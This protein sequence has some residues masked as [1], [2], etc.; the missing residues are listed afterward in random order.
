MEERIY[1][2]YASILPPNTKDHQ[3]GDSKQGRNLQAG[4]K[5]NPFRVTAYCLAPHG[6]YIIQGHLPRGGTIPHQSNQENGLCTCLQAGL[7]YH[8]LN[9]RPSFPD[10]SMFMSV[11]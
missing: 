7:V 5:Q 10:M 3:C 8:V 4:V 9:N 11:R 6:S 1:L 2:S